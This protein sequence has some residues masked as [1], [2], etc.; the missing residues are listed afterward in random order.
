MGPRDRRDRERAELRERILN[1]ARELFAEFGYEGVSMRKIA[2]RI[3]YS[4]TAIY[5]H[6]A[7]KE[8][9]FRELCTQDFLLLST[10][11]AALARVADPMQRLFGIGEAY[12]RFG[13]THPFHYRLMFMTPPPAVS[14]THLPGA[15]RFSTLRPGSAAAMTAT[16]ATAQS[17]CARP[18]TPHPSGAPC[19][20]SARAAATCSASTLS[21]IHI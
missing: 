8:T 13:V 9:L 21:L 6:F 15:R 2:E 7:D 5:L 19:G 3:E 12:V 1:A 4:P 11:F 17:A 20:T 16:P 14:Y 18:A 10:E